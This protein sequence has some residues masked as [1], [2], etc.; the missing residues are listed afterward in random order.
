[1]SNALHAHT[2]IVTAI[3]GRGLTVR[4]TEYRKLQDQD[5]P[6]ALTSRMAYDAAGRLTAF[7][8]PRLWALAQQDAA[9]PANRTYRY[10]LAGVPLLS[11]SVD[12]GWELSLSA[13]A[14][15]VVESW[16]TR[17]STRQIRY[18]PYLRPVATVEID[19]QQNARTI[20]RSVYADSSDDSAEHNRC[21][22]LA[23][24]DDTAGSLHF[25]DY[26]VQGQLLSQPRQ[27][28]KTPELPDWTDATDYLD[29]VETEAFTT[30]WQYNAVAEPTLQTD[31]RGNAQRAAYSVAGNLSGVYLQL[32]SQDE[33]TLVD[34]MIYNAFGQVEKQTAGNGVVSQAVYETSTGLLQS[35]TAGRA[36]NEALQSLHYGYDPVGNILQIEDSAQPIRFFANQR[37]EPIS[38]YRYDTL[39]QLIE[40]TGREVKTGAS[41]GP[42]LPGLQ[43]LPPDPNQVSNYTQSYDYDSAGNLLQMRHVGAQAFT[44]TMLVAPHSNRSLPAGEVEVDFANGFDANGNLLQLVRGQTLEWDLRNQLQQITTV[45]RA[46]AANDNEHYIYEGQGQ[47]CRKINSTQTSSRTL[48]SEVRYLPGLEIRTTADGEILHVITLQAGRS[49]VRVLHWQAGQPSGIANDQV[50]Y[51]LDDH[52]GSSLMEL[53]Q[54]GGLISQEGYYPFGGTAWWAARSAVEAKYKTV[55]YSGKELDASGLYYYGFRYYAPWLQRW[56]NPDPAGDIDGLNLYQMLGNNPVSRFDLDGRMD[57]SG[58]P[59]RKEAKRK[60]IHNTVVHLSALKLIKERVLAARQQIENYLDHDERG[61][62]AVRRSTSLMGQTTAKMAGSTGGGAAAGV[63]AGVIAC[64]ACGPPGWVAGGAVL[65]GGFAAAK[66]SG[67]ITEKATDKLRLNTPINFKSSDLEPEKI[68]EEAEKTAHSLLGT[69]MHAVRGYTDIRD[70][71]ARQNVLRLVAG[72]ALEQTPVVGTA[73][74][75]A[76]EF[77]ELTYEIQHSENQIEPEKWE[78]LDTHLDALETALLERMNALKEEFERTGIESVKVSV[79]PLKSRASLESL[80]KK[81]TQVIGIIKETRDLSIE[82]RKP[83]RQNSQFKMTR[84]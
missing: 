79:I 17:G 72:T 82:A 59:D 47:R 7:W 75:Y 26:G 32:N 50:R 41:H 43:N 77:V 10:N 61:I 34:G 39:Y 16:D 54:Q 9:S 8:D 1:M 15:N 6:L 71:K 52:L 73:I 27:F 12:A 48:N 40:A 57:S 83:S 64:G 35:L 4:A 29:L 51:S 5:E 20:I 80:N 42:A 69:V 74:K 25:P 2:P 37:I 58:P 44:R 11:E 55:R 63:L 53:D 60:L 14:S 45:T 33:T 23:R 36:G 62:S 84:L 3:D 19:A 66:A 67:Y 21:G 24:L 13:E 70:K 81:T 30:H 65:V 46:T 38:R 76:P 28:L 56:I 68:F 49:N 18:D 31:A 78:F 22:Q